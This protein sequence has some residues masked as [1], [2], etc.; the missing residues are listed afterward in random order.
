MD[1]YWKNTADGSELSIIA[2]L[3]IFLSNGFKTYNPGSKS[4][5]RYP[6][7]K[8]IDGARSMAAIRNYLLE[9]RS[10]GTSNVMHKFFFILAYTSDHLPKIRVSQQALCY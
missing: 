7:Q 4:S 3:T 9:S 2:F 6:I 10:V 8:H 5:K 1:Y